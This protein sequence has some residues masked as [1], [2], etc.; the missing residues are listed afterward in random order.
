MVVRWHSLILKRWKFTNLLKIFR[1]LHTDATY[2]VHNK[3]SKETNLM[4]EQLHEVMDDKKHELYEL[5]EKLTI[6]Q[7]QY[8]IAFIKVYFKL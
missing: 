1:K 8:L 7:V 2:N 5:I 3:T 4:E 6:R